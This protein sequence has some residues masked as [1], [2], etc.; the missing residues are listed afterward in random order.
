MNHKKPTLLLVLLAGLA[1]GAGFVWFAT[2]GS[3]DLIDQAARGLTA[4]A[5]DE[6]DNDPEHQKVSS[7]ASTRASPGNDSGNEGT[8]RTE[9]DARGE[10]VGARVVAAAVL[11]Q[12]ASG[13]PVADALVE[14]RG[15]NGI[16]DQRRTDL[17][18]KATLMLPPCD[19]LA[20]RASAEGAFP[21]GIGQHPFGQP[22]ILVLGEAAMVTG[23]VKD[24]KGEPV[25]GAAPQ[26]PLRDA[27][28]I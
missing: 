8:E 26:S 7:L 18:G 24:T 15:E 27:F 9:L 28:R 12:T 25:A 6:D 23:V 10:Q 5:N 16:T 22:L 21:A 13:A 1:L 3:P 20:L 4:P 19:T 14:A 11:V 17:E 2:P